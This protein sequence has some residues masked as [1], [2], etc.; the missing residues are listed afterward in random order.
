MVIAKAYCAAN[1]GK[2]TC[3]VFKLVV[4]VALQNGINTMKPS[5]WKMCSECRL[6]L[7]MALQISRSNCIT[8]INITCTA[9]INTVW[10][11]SLQMQNVRHGCM[12]LPTPWMCCL[13]SSVQSLDCC[14]R[15]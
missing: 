9:I 5:L 12:C 1:E 15:C 14:L 8:L 11:A 2:C 4:H 13:C 10:A 6:R 3:V 7:G